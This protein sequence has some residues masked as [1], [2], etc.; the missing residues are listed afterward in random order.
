MLAGDGESY[1]A[2][3]MV[4]G[5]TWLMENF[6]RI[7][8]GLIAQKPWIIFCPGYDGVVP[9]WQ[10]ASQVDDW[11]L[12]ARQVVGPTGYLAIELSAGYASW[13]DGGANWDSPAGLACDTILQEFPYRLQDNWNQVWQI[14]ARLQRPYHR[15]ANQP[16]DDDPDP[17]FYLGQSTP[18][19][20]RYFV[21]FEYDTY[22]WVRSCPLSQVEEH[23]AYLSAL[24]DHPLVG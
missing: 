8:D 6:Q 13:G 5:H 21:N 11:L 18:R 14:V 16:A 22:G 24:T 7:H 2:D 15:P 12:H 19:G 17:P 20:R 1:N 10:P 3:G 9:A 23:R 4:Y